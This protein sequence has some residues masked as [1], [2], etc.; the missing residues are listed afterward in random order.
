MHSDTGKEIKF[1]EALYKCI[2][3]FTAHNCLS[4]R[5][6]LV[7]N[8]A[9]ANLKA[10]REAIA[11]KKFDDAVKACDRILLWESGNYNA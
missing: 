11:A 10:A 8:N 6:R 3:S 1:L 2:R 9:K 7:M 5:V 4:E